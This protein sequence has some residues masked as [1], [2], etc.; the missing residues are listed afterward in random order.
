VLL[1]RL[2]TDLAK[3]RYVPLT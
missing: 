1:T 3:N 2:L